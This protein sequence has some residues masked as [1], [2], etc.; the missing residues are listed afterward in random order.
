MAIPVKDLETK[1]RSQGLPL[2]TAALQF[3]YTHPFAASVLIGT[4]DASLLQ[5]NLHTI[6]AQIPD[7][8]MGVFDV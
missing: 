8:F 5:R 6:T 7:R 3:A 1:A 2:V 4:A